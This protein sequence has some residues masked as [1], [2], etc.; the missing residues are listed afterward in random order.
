MEFSEYIEKVKEFQNGLGGTATVS[1]AMNA[2]NAWVNIL[3]IEQQ[4]SMNLSA[5]TE[6]PRGPQLVV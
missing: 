4:A 5:K 3:I 1:E 6:Q 2:V